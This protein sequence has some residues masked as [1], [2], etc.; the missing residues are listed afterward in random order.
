M[1]PSCIDDDDDESSSAEDLDVNV[2]SVSDDEISYGTVRDFDAV[3]TRHTLGGEGSA[4]KL[5]RE[6]AS[7]I[8]KRPRLSVE[9]AGGESPSFSGN[10]ECHPEISL[11]TPTCSDTQFKDV[12][13]SILF[14]LSDTI[15]S[16][17]QL[18]VNGLVTRLSN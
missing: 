5:V 11:D 12:P 9:C 13:P 17:A 18:Q 15:F 8:R 16:G 10:K 1:D 6:G 7:P 14:A 4:E 3:D 2:C